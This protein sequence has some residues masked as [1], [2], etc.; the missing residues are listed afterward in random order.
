MV[1]LPYRDRLVLLSRYLPQLVMESSGK[2]RDLQVRLRRDGERY[3]ASVPL[4]QEDFG[5]KPYSTFF[6]GLKVKSDVVVRLSLPA[7]AAT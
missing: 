7:D 3:V 6:G 4:R 5:I 1:M 2:E